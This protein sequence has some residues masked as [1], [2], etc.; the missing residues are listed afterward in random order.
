MMKS[1]HTGGTIL[2]TGGGGFI[3]ANLTHRLIDSNYKVHLLW[4]KNSDPWRLR[5]IENKIYFHTVELSDQKKLTI[6]MKKINPVAIFHLATYSSYRN[7]EDVKQIFDVSVNGTLNLLLA[8]REIPYKIFVNTGSSSEYGF[9]DKPMKESDL[10][11]PVSFYASAKSSQTLLCQTFFYHY[12]KPVVTIRP[13]SVYGPYEQKDRFIPII[14]RA[15][16]SGS[17][18]KLTSGKQ[19]RDFIYIDDLTDIYIKIIKNANRIAGKVLN[20]GTGHEYTNDEIVKTL[21]KVTGKKVTIEKGSFPKRIWDSPHWVANTK[22]VK[23]LLNWKPNYSLEKGL[24]NTY[25]WFLKNN[26][27]YEEQ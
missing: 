22:N 21:F 23:K 1:A 17:S 11:E 5:D 8:S 12:K 3:G 25:D 15:L 10:L 19:R 9:K 24:G 6:L 20:A 26:D 18:I 13:F 16:I 2:I 4:K 27:L 14:T 7:Q